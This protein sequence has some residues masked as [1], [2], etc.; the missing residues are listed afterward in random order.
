MVKYLLVW[1]VVVGLVVLAVFT[2]FDPTV[3]DPCKF[4][5]IMD[6]VCNRPTGVI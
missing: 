3:G 4:P 2:M 1:L 5:L 6:A